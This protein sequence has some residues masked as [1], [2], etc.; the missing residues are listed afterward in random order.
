MKAEE[1]RK[2]LVLVGF[3]N[4]G[5]V[6]R[7]EVEYAEGGSPDSF[8]KIRIADTGTNR[9]DQGVCEYDPEAQASLFEALDDADGVVIIAPYKDEYHVFVAEYD[10]ADLHAPLY[11]LGTFK[12]D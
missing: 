11:F 8:V 5:Q 7:H 1:F 12:I 3:F 4:A 6:K 10:S 9:G 2:A